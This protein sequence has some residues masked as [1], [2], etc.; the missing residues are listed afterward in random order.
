MSSLFLT[1]VLSFVIVILALIFLGIG[2]LMT[3]KS[4]IQPGACGRDPT[5]NRDQ[6]EGCG[7]NISCQ[8]CE[9]PD[10]NKKR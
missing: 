4:K 7:S 9:K 1:L 2:L 6:T 10:E 3:G 8:L 5:K